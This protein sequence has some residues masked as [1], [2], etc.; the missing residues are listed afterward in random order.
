MD[1]AS[2]VVPVAWS[3]RPGSA[4]GVLDDAAR[5]ADDVAREGAV[6][7]ALVRAGTFPTTAEAAETAVTAIR[8]RLTR[9]FGLE[10]S[11]IRVLYGEEYH[12][13]FIRVDN[14]QMTIHADITTF[15]AEDTRLFIDMW[16]TRGE[17]RGTGLSRQMLDEVE[18]V[19]RDYGAQRSVIVGSLR[20]AWNY[21]T[22]MGYAETG[23]RP[24]T[25]DKILA[26]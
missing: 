24:F 25:H 10:E 23:S 19:A 5:Y 8:A 13:I 11:D 20:K 2:V 16:A 17:A 9:R 4:A 12:S 15:G 6:A 18:Q 7:P 21:W 1:V 3:T 14:E 22:H 26:R